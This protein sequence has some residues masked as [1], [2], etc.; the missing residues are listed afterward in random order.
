MELSFINHGTNHRILSVADRST[1]RKIS[2]QVGA[3]TR[4][5]NGNGRK[6]NVLQIPDFLIAGAESVAS[7]QQ[8]SA[9][10]YSQPLTT[11]GCLVKAKPQKPLGLGLSRQPSNPS[12]EQKHLRPTTSVPASLPLSSNGRPIPSSMSVFM[13]PDLTTRLL[14]YA[15]GQDVLTN[16][17]RWVKAFR[18]SRQSSLRFLPLCYGHSKCLDDAIDCAAGRLQLCLAGNGQGHT[19]TS[20]LQVAR[21]YGRALRSLNVALTS[22]DRVDWTMWYATLTLLLSEVL[23]ESSRHGWIMHARGAFDILQA[24]GPDNIRTEI[25]KDMFVTQAGGMIIEA[26]FAN[27]DSYLSRPEWQKALQS[28]IDPSAQLRHRSES[29][30]KLWLIL[31]SVPELFRSVTEAVMQ[32]RLEEKFPLMARLHILLDDLTAWGADLRS[33]DGTFRTHYARRHYQSTTTRYLVYTA[34][35]YRFITAI[36]ANSASM[37]EPQ[38]METISYIGQ[39]IESH[40]LKAASPPALRLA[41]KVVLSIEATTADW[42][43]PEVTGTSACSGTIEPKVFSYWSSLM[44]RAI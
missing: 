3:A 5:A 43:Q 6:V 33:E 21:L 40:Q 11:T 17:L 13:L 20:Q 16:P 23:D 14:D 22:S 7:P 19:S 32:Q 26:T 24:L 31:A 2:R 9:G 36:D 10:Y 27:I 29:T 44:G 18:L 39:V 30:V 42:S 28:A 12:L 37:T 35:A 1:I 15:T 34:L 25:E 41:K 38:A 4:K 8:Q